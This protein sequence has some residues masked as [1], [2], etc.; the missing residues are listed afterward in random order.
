MTERLPSYLS[1]GHLPSNTP[2]L[3]GRRTRWNGFLVR[4]S[5]HPSVPPDVPLLPPVDRRYDLPRRG[6]HVDDGIRRLGLEP[7]RR[8]VRTKTNP[9]VVT[10]RMSDC[11]LRCGSFPVVRNHHGRSDLPR[12]RCMCSVVSGRGV[13]EGDVSTQEP[14]YRV[15]NL[16]SPMQLLQ[17]WEPAT[18]R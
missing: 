15:G 8:S 11:D 16:D 10:F 5:L 13:H 18:S 4:F 6:L 7:A 3:P 9:I 17:C 12:L 14:W 1:P 2:P